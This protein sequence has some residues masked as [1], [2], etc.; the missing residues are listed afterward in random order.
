[1]T[2]K[3]YKITLGQQLLMLS[4]L[5]LTNA[6]ILIFCIAKFDWTIATY[7]VIGF[8]LLV[9]II[10]TMFVHCQY[11]IKNSGLTITIDTVDKSIEYSNRGVIVKKSF[12]DISKLVRTSSYGRGTGWYSFAEYRY[13]TLV[14]D[15]NSEHILTCL[16][17]PNIENNL[18]DKLPIEE[19]K[20]L[21][22]LA[23]I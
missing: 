20:E 14:Y 8:S 23:L 4:H 11:L 18:R 19:E 17:I 13:Y 9:S 1:M 3:T 22:V 16:L 5:L 12:E 2:K 10:P 15:D 7:S 21:K 6:V